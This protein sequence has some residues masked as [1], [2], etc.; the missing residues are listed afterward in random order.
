MEYKRGIFIA[1]LFP[2]IT[3]CLSL[4]S[5]PGE[6]TEDWKYVDEQD[7]KDF[8]KGA[9]IH[10]E[11]CTSGNLYSYLNSIKSTS[12]NYVVNTIGDTIFTGNVLLSSGV[13]IS[14]R[15]DGGSITMPFTGPGTGW[16]FNVNNGAKLI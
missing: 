4:V 3:L 7:V 14:I 15:G 9:I 6:A 5:C 10:Y 8:G 12:G 1:V 16:A 13:R 11:D 2:V